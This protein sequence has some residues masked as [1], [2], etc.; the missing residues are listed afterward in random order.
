MAMTNSFSAIAR[1]AAVAMILFQMM[2]PQLQAQNFPKAST[3]PR[4]VNDFASVLGNTALLENDLVAYND[5]TSTQIAV[6]TVP[7]TEGYEIASYAIGLFNE[8]GIGQASKDNGILILVAVQD[9]KTFI[10]T[11]RDVE[12]KLPDIICKR[13]IENE[14]LPSF[15]IGDYELGIRNAIAKIQG[16]LDGTYSVDDSDVVSAPQEQPIRKYIPFIIFLIII[17]IIIS[18]NS[19]GGGSTYSRG[20]YSSGGVFFGGGGFGGGGSSSG[21]G[22]FGGFGGGSSGGGGAGGS[23]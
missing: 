9:R 19:G 22:G 18:K 7:S 17:I 21:G 5:S 16:Y 13:I 10:V 4:I 20:G 1:L 8:W 15:R 14:M 12:D 6:V 3:P 23:W 2:M 11:G